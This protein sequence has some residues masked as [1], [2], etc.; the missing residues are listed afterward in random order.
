[1]TSRE[2]ILCS[3]QH[4]EPDRVPVDFGATP[5]SGISAI[6][7]GRL[8]R[9]LG[10]A[11][12][13]TRIY[14]T[15]QELAQPEDSI[16][17]LFRADALDIERAFT[18]DD[19][20]WY[21]VKLADGSMAEYPVWTKVHQQADG[22]CHYYNSEG[23]LIGKKPANGTFYDGC[24]FP[25]ENGYPENFRQLAAD[26]EKSIWAAMKMS[27]AHLASQPDYQIRSSL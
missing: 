20:D 26:M 18:K 23:L 22:S 17:A 14:D 13:K 27:P 24:L 25:Y 9:Y 1:M 7:Y 10:L 6:A 15:V 16:L 2:R 11:N 8:T 12:S 3:L 21:P 4:H 5:S 19:S